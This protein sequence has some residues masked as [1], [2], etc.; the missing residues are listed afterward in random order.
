MKMLKKVGQI[1]AAV[2]LA[3][4]IFWLGSFWSCEFRTRDHYQSEMKD[5]FLRENLV[6]E[7]ST[8]K[9]LEYRDGYA[10]VYVRGIQSGSEGIIVYDKDA[11]EW[12][13]IYW[14]TIWSRQGSAHG[15]V[16]PYIR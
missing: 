7:D 2:L 16:W 13:L 12:Q 11:E 4:L 3:I 6:E 9:L 5:A 15:L 14:N 8:V 1:A 10:K